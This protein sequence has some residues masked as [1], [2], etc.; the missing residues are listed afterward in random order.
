MAR[1]KLQYWSSVITDCLSCLELAPEN[2]KAHYYLSQAQ[3]EIHDFEAALSNAL[4][5]HALCVTTNDKSLAAVTTLVLRCKHERWED[6]EKKRLRETRDLER[7]MVEVLERER[8]EMLKDA[9]DE[10]ERREIEEEAEAKIMRLREVFEKSR[11]DDEKKREVPEW[12]IDD[13][14][15]GIMVDPVVVSSSSIPYI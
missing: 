3:L 7:S 10:A 13:I 4:Q 11:A 12:A 9:I 5:A 8:D 1:L 6:L 15:F 14:S 2:M